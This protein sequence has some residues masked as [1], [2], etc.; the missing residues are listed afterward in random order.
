MNEKEYQRPSPE[1]LLELAKAEEKKNRGKLTIYFGA[2]P[3]VGKTYT[4]LL[5]AHQQKQEGS[6]VVVGYVETHG[7]PETDALLEGIEILPPLIVKYKGM[8]LKEVDLAK[9]LARKP[10]LVLVDELAHTDAPG[11]RNA[12]RYQDIEEILNAGIDVYTTMNVQHIESLNDI[13]HQITDIRVHETVPDTAFEAADE[14]KLVDLPPEEL[15]KRLH[16][17]KVYVK[18][19]ARSAVKKFFRPGN[20]LALRQLALR[21]VAGSVDEK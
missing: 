18:D 8:L 2:A 1:A 11:L 12:K 14:I 17:G 20:L 15:L 6:D 19:M 21:T 9:V 10:N 16:E 7:R 5:D 4:M 3:G 13:I